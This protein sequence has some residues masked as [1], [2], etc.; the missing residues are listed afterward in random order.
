MSMIESV[1]TC[2]KKYA[3]FSGRASRSEYW[4]FWLLYFIVDVASRVSVHMIP[5]YLLFVLVEL[6]LIIPLLAVSAR[7][8]HD[9]NRSAWW[10]LLPVVNIVFYC[11]AT[12]QK[13][14]TSQ[15]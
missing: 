6:A 8:L 1:T 7:R 9:T 13:S 5:L 2:L 14:G 10:M 15:T 3:D 11:Q 12:A 4:Y